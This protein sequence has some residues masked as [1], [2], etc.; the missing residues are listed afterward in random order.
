MSPTSPAVLERKEINSIN[1]R[2]D[3]RK[4]REAMISYWADA[5]IRPA[6]VIE[7]SGNGARVVIKG[8]VKTNDKIGVLIESEGR[9]TCTFAR[10]AWTSQLATSKTVVGLEFLRTSYERAC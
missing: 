10:V 2:Q 7:C 6:A 9:H 5:G 8:N 4:K 1:R 3:R